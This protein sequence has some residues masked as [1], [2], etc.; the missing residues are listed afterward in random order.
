[1]GTS[2]TSSGKP[3]CRGLDLEKTSRLRSRQNFF[4]DIPFYRI[5]LSPGDNGALT[6]AAEMMRPKNQRWLALL[7]I[8]VGIYLSVRLGQ[9]AYKEVRYRRELN[10]LSGALKPGT[11]R[12][13]VE[14]YLRS[15]NIEFSQMCCSGEK[16]KAMDDLV[17]VGHEKAGLIC[18]ERHVYV[19]FQ[20]AAVEPN[21]KWVADSDRLVGTT[22]FRSVCLDM[23]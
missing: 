18:I 5:D 8:I 1:M 15:R 14:S 23:P 19:A 11:K 4:L 16:L 7:G 17:Q 20:F 6:D 2:Q 21:D 3:N 12:S 13:E 22:L 10:A 9:Y